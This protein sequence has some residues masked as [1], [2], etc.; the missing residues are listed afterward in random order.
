M[1]LGAGALGLGGL[2]AAG[3][4]VEAGLLGPT[5]RLAL[6]ALLGLALIALA[7]RLRTRM[8]AEGRPDHVPA[9]L[10]AGGLV[11]LYGAAAAAYALYGLIEP[12][13]AFFLLA[14]VAM[15]GVSLGLLF[16]GLVGLLGAV[17]AY[18]VPAIVGSGHPSAWTLF[19]YL[20]VVAASLETL[21]G[22]ARWPWLGWLNLAG[23]FFWALLWLVTRAG[24]ADALPMAAFALVTGLAG[25]ATLALSQRDPQGGGR[26]SRALVGAALI[27]L[28]LSLAGIGYMA[29][30]MAALALLSLACLGAGLL[31]PEERWLAAMAAAADLLAAAAWQIPAR[32]LAEGAPGP[33]RPGARPAP[34]GCPG[35]GSARPG[36]L[37]S[38]GLC[39]RW[40]ARWPHGGRRDPA[41]GPGSRSPCRSRRWPSATGASPALPSARRSPG[42]RSC[43]RPAISPWPSGRRAVR[44]CARRRPPMPWAWRVPWRSVPRSSSRRAG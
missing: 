22:R 27:L 8:R 29:A 15:L 19:P 10:A 37:C 9:A 32:A 13:V 24:P 26:S 35:G 43:S 6:V 12:P 14:L 42:R 25:Q 30:P 5:V 18:L 20:A 7:A 16:G 36:A 41:F 28:V 4:A 1:W 23:A 40:P 17:G 21:A 44:R 3:Y 11:A 38:S 33:A 39:G 34:L 31:R 2:F